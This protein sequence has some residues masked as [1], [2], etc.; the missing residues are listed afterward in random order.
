[1]RYLLQRCDRPLRPARTALWSAAIGY[2][3]DNHK[4]LGGFMG[5]KSTLGQR[6]LDGI[7]RV[8]NRLP[9]PAT[10]FLIAILIV[11][12][13]SVV[14]AAAGV[15][16]VH[17]GTGK[18]VA[19]VSLAD[20]ANITRFLSELPKVFTSFHPL[21]LVLVVMLGV[22]VAE[23]TGLIG[24]SLAALVRAVPAKL[25]TPTVVFAG[26]QSSLASDAGY[27]VLTPLAAALFYSVGRHPI[28][29][30]AAAFAGVSG[31]FSA[32]LLITSLDPLLGGITQE[33]ARLY[34]PA[35]VVNAT[36]NY[37][38]MMAYVPLFTI[39]GWVITDW[40]IE[41]RLNKMNP[42]DG[43]V[44]KHS[45]DMSPEQ[46][47]A[48]KRGLRWAGWTLLGSI[49][50]I[51]WMTVPDGAIL[52]DPAARD[53][54]NPFYASIV[55]I[56]FLVFLLCGIAYGIGARVINND[57]DVVKMM[58]DT[59]ASMGGYL[60]L[61]FAASVFIALF[62][63]SQLGTILAING[64]GFLKEAGITGMPLLIGIILVS[65]LVNILVGS[66]SAKWAIL[67]P[68]MVPMLMGIG[69]APEATQAAY[70][71]GDAFTNIITPLLPYM[72]LILIMC[73]RYVKGF[74][75]GS[76]IA[77]MLPYSIWFGITSTALFCVWYALDLPLG[78][79][80]YSTIPVPGV[81]APAAAGG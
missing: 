13:L 54:L 33:A 5:E 51:L 3:S 77:T 60:V 17:P 8:G 29:G 63:W 14:M 18:E 42:V 38:L 24:V 65:S 36:A 37:Y 59:M 81:T 48:E 34:D 47:L 43:N 20:P 26:V 78:P 9:D 72:P 46:V 68:V 1:M 45:D 80:I 35:Y 53:P 67:A 75:I 56:L 16:A 11:I 76:L 39:V 12:A 31:G 19:A 52:R 69:V 61:A 79:G 73:Q 62:N 44:P 58:N 30:L 49:A 32:N 41:P 2:V 28:A 27:V 22:G 71:V 7:E 40:V 4:N 64:A 25:L 6:L 55:T 66:A 21:G 10:L 74:G 15:S 70:R 50:A 57:R 23:R